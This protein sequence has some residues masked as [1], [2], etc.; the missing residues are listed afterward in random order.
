MGVLLEQ[1]ESTIPVEFQ[2]PQ[3]IRTY[4][5]DGKYPPMSQ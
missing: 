5:K 3:E 2:L 4:F 1:L